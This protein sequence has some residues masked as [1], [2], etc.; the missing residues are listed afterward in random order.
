MTSLQIE[1]S[2][3]AIILLILIIICLAKNRMSIKNSIAWLLLPLVFIIIAIFP[4]P[5]EAFAKWLG[6]ETLANFIFVAIIAL[7]I[8]I[9]FFLTISLSRQQAEITKL[10]QEISI[11]KSQTKGSKNGKK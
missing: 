11:L 6:F 10:I 5:I 2:I 4:S 9:C 1:I 8:I 3:A 7:L